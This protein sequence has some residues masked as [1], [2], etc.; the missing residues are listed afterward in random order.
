M[1]V[2]RRV[3]LIEVV[4]RSRRPRDR[5]RSSTDIRYVN[6]HWDARLFG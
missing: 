4:S 3:E 5:Y 1:H 2:S 6:L